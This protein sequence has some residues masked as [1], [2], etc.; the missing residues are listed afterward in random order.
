[1]H[2]SPMKVEPTT[3]QPAFESGM[4]K[5]LTVSKTEILRREAEH[6]KVADLNPKKRG[7]KKKVK[8]PVTE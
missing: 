1:M 6:K 8:A 4:R 7:P 2:N 3:Y 5:I